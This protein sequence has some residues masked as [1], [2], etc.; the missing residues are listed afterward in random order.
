M[1]STLMDRTNRAAPDIPW[2]ALYTRHQHEKSVANV[3]ANKGFETFLP[4]YTS[5]S[6]WKD[7]TKILSLALFPGYVF[8]KGGIENRRLLILT[9]PGVHSLVSTA[10]EPAVI[11][12]IEIEAIR[13]V[14]ESGARVDAHPF[15][16]C[17]DRAR[18]KCG[19][20]TGIEGI[21]VRKK[22]AW[23]LVLSVEMLGKSAA[24]EVDAFQVERVSSKPPTEYRR[25][26]TTTGS[27]RSRLRLVG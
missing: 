16:N 1:S 9:T 25:D 7:R 3:L 26:N 13:R 19:P 17:G 11:P 15:L 2:Y 24:L 5:S 8:L 22:S 18:I 21:L 27:V 20:L 14:V 12:V 23:R 6:R 10:G 4:L